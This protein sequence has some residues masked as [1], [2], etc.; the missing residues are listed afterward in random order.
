MVGAGLHQVHGLRNFSHH[1]FNRNGFGNR[2]AW[3][4]FEHRFPHH[5]CGW[6]G[7][8]FWPF[9]IG[10]VLTAVLWPWEEYDPF[11]WY[12]SDYL[13]SGIYW[14]G[15]NGAMGYA[16]SDVYDVYGNEARS[17][18]RAAG[19]PHGNRDRLESVN[20]PAHTAFSE[21]CTGLAPGLTSLP[22]DRIQHEVQPTGAQLAAFEDLRSAL[23]KAGE[24]I[25]VSCSN[26]VPLTPVKRLEAVKMRLT[27]MAEVVHTVR[28]PLSDFY[29]SLTA[30]QRQR[31]D[32]VGGEGAT[33]GPRVKA[34]A[35][36]DWAGLCTERAAA[37]SE[38]PAQRIEEAIRPTGQQRAAFD[39]LKMAST[40][41]SHR[42]KSSCPAQ[43][44]TGIV[45]RLQ[46]VDARLAAML[47]AVEVV[48]PALEEFYAS[49]S[50]EQ[51]ALFNSWGEPQRQ[52]GT[53]SG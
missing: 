28:G 26:E 42:L 47:S 53:N 19:D 43:M 32:A 18:S 7:P 39:A 21:A 16:A 1:P 20:G 30:G 11:W 22:I 27:T 48:R 9:F 15:Y 23:S 52:A 2:V 33:H 51:K 36:N 12:G 41:A 49:L 17:R 37:F 3:N 13:L 6:F 10:D 24:M 8:V 25:K 50:D 44:P 4:R 45:D 40:E 29:N 38:L 34:A 46:A 31:L 35:S 14:A 5:C